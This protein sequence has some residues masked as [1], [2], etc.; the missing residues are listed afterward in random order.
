MK[1]EEILKFAQKSIYTAVNYLGKWNGYDV[2][3]PGFDD[4]DEHCIGFPSFIL[5]KVDAIRWTEDWEESQ[6]IMRALYPHD[7]EED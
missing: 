6:E 3:E 2:W 5:V 1:Q 7:E 4:E